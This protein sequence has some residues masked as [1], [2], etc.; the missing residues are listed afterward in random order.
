MGYSKIGLKLYLIQ[1]S[2]DSIVM[3]CVVLRCH[4][5]D[6]ADDEVNNLL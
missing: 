5:S 6:C 1:V 3:G 4:C 2:N